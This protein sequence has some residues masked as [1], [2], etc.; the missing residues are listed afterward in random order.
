[1]LTV[2][3]V[4]TVVVVTP[5][6]LRIEYLVCAGACTPVVTTPFPVEVIVE[7]VLIVYDEGIGGT[8]GGV[9]VESLLLRHSGDAGR[10]VG[11]RVLGLT[12][13]VLSNVDC[14]AVGDFDFRRTDTPLTAVIE[15]LFPGKLATSSLPSARLPW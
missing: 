5:F 12:R 7:G 1:V 14:V 3:G 11:D 8:G 6:E 10:C 4:T 2:G 15:S 9:Q 13:S